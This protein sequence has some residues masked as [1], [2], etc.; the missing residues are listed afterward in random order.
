MDYRFVEVEIED[1]VEKVYVYGEID[2][3]GKVR[4]LDYGIVK[5]EDVVN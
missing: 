1:K 5:I 3:N 2:G 4:I